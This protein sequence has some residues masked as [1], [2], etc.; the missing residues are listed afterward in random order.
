MI[1]SPLIKCY[2]SSVQYLLVLLG[3]HIYGTDHSQNYFE[4]ILFIYISEIIQEG[5]CATQSNQDCDFFVCASM[6]TLI[7]GNVL[8]TLL[9]ENVTIIEYVATHW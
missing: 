8:F 9:V 4:A 6:I 3:G 5:N 7:L 1:Q 2:F